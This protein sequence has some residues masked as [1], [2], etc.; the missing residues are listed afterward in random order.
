M[1]APR[2]DTGSPPLQGVCH[3]LALNMPLMA[4]QVVLPGGG[5]LIGPLGL[6]SWLA[7]STFGWR[8]SLSWTPWAIEWQFFMCT[9]TSTC[10]VM[11]VRMIWLTRVEL[12]ARCIPISFPALVPLRGG[13][14][15]SKMWLRCSS[16]CLAMRSLMPSIRVQKGTTGLVVHPCIFPPRPHRPLTPPPS[17]PSDFACDTPEPPD[18]QDFSEGKAQQ[19]S[20]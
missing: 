4:P 6:G 11:I 18:S 7:M 17:S 20:T 1:P 2:S 10:M 16:L 5:K 14:S 15:K 8:S 13:A 9:P 19:N 3:C 12:A